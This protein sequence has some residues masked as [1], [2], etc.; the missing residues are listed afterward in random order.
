MRD[1][2][3]LC[4]WEKT[5]AVR[6]PYSHRGVSDKDGTAEAQ[7]RRRINGLGDLDGMEFVARIDIGQDTNGEDKN[8]IRVA[9]T[10]DHREYAA[11]MGKITPQVGAARR[12][13][14]GRSA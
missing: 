6:I 10:P 13:P 7:L 8:E 9:V 1:Y 4:R 5:L 12:V 3:T 11:L 14:T 2:T